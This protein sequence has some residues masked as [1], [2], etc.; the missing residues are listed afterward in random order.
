M[1]NK[2]EKAECN[3]MNM[4][5]IVCDACNRAKYIAVLRYF[6]VVVVGLVQQRLLQDMVGS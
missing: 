6:V 1:I 2:L 4:V 3:R 5:I